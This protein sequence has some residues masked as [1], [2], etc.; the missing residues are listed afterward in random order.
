VKVSGGSPTEEIGEGEGGAAEL[1]VEPAA[2]VV[3]GGLG[4]EAGIEAVQGVWPLVFEAE[5]C[6][7]LGVDGRDD[8]AE[9]GEPAAQRFGPGAR[10]GAVGWADHLRARVCLPVGVAVGADAAG[11]RKVG[12]ASGDADGGEAGVLCVSRSEEGFGQGLIPGAD[13]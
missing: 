2:V 12:L 3:E 8:L 10:S 1:L 9:A 5:G 11:V 6:E 7:E 4:G 13:P